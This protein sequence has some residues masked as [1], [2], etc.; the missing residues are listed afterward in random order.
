MM[1]NCAEERSGMEV[2]VVCCGLIAFLLGF[3]TWMLNI[4]V[5]G[6]TEALRLHEL[7]EVREYAE[8][9]ER[10]PD[11]WC[12]SDLR[13]AREETIRIARRREMP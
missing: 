11:D 9:G 1:S 13:W 10:I 3:W 2:W 5:R 6:G 12:Y 7:K 4:L 8:M